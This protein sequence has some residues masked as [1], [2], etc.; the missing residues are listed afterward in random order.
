MT[1]SLFARK[2][3]IGMVHVGALPGTPRGGEDL[4]SITTRACD[5][6]R[7]LEDAGFDGIII[8]NM[9]D[10]PYVHGD[11]MG[12]EIVAGMTL[13]SAKVAEAID[14]PFGVQIL[15]GGNR[16]ALAVA[17]ATGGRYI[18]CENFVF[19]HVADEGLLPE[20]EAG[21]LLRYRRA[22][23]AE[24]VAICCDVK[25]KHASHAITADLSLADCIEAAEFFGADAVIITGTATGK[26]TSIE[27]VALARRSTVLPVMVGSGV[28][29][30]TVAPLFEHADAL[31]VGSYLKRDGLWSNALDPHRCEAIVNA[32]AAVR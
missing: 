2:T 32:A 22:I 12:P 30:E 27:D 18:R 5:E 23:G 28:T 21:A 1:C 13:I 17:H 15:S 7:L 26:P 31:V 3:L 8:E 16:H 29:P 25:K 6:A 14:I 4:D 11:K 9:H 24:G 20:A 10:R 19:S